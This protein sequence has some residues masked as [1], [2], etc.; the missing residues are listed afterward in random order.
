MCASPR[1]NHALRTVPPSEVASYAQLHDDAV[2]ETLVALLGSLPPDEAD[3]ARSLAGLPAALGGL[4]DAL[5]V[6]RARMP[7]FATSCV[8]YLGAGGGTAPCLQS[9]AGARSHTCPEWRALAEEARPRPLADAGLGDWPHGWQSHASRTRNL[10][11][12]DSVLL[13]SLPPAACA[14]LRSQVGPH[15]GAWLTAVPAEHAMTLERQAMQVA[16]RRRL[17]LARPLRGAARK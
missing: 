12:R 3:G 7:E 4:G 2:W 17:R 13:P 15:A 11:F 16:L 14:L 6:L 9:A 10:H 5:P 8:D 1:A